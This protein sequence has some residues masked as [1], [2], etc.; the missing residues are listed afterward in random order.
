MYIYIYIYI[1]SEVIVDFQWHFPM[2]FSGVFS[3]N[4]IHLSVVCSKGLSLVQ[5]ILTGNVQWMFSG[6]F[7]WNFTFCEF[8]CVIFC[9]DPGFRDFKVRGRCGLDLRMALC[10]G[11]AA[12]PIVV[13]I[14]LVAEFKYRKRESGN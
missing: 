4:G 3:S 10:L 6:I 2:D 7:Q 13:A 9:P 8:W 1:T 14:D 12:F 5:W 11:C